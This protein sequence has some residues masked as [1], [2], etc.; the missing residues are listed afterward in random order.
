MQFKTFLILCTGSV[1]SSLSVAAQKLSRKCT[2]ITWSNLGQSSA[3]EVSLCHVERDNTCNTNSICREKET[4]IYLGD[5]QGTKSTMLHHQSVPI[6][7]II[8]C[9]AASRTTGQSRAVAQNKK[10]TFPPRFQPSH[11][12]STSPYSV[13]LHQTIVATSIFTPCG[14]ILLTIAC[15]VLFSTC[16]TMLYKTTF[17]GISGKIR[18]HQ[19][20]RHSHILHDEA[21]TKRITDGEIRILVGLHHYSTKKHT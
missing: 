8:Q 2:I 1:G 18:P 6:D 16:G 11:Y 3:S 19:I 5:S 10:P 15:T 9:R 20:F 4:F 12:P 21:Y 13:F 17:F 7:V 14:K